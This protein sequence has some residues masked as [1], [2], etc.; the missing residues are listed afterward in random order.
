MWP[1]LRKETRIL[2]LRL[3]AAGSGD[4]STSAVAG[5]EEEALVLDGDI[6]RNRARPP[7]P[8]SSM[9]LRSPWAPAVGSGGGGDRRRRM[10]V[11]AVEVGI[12][13]PGGDGRR[14]RC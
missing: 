1:D 2:D 8:L 12:L 7:D 14:W 9:P 5:L 3:Q 11:Y 6:V 10:E 13:R 4:S